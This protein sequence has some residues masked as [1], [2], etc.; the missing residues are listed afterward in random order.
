[1][2]RERITAVR[3]SITDIVNGIFGDENGPRVISP[4]GV[5]L[6][7]VLIVG[8]IVDRLTGKDN[9]ASITIDDGTE[10]IRAKAWGNEASALQDVER[11]L[12][13]GRR[14]LFR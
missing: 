3:A 1:M 13:A 4:D 11:D 14:V 9:F 7:R 12:E 2:M 8:H 10:T 5:E 6:R